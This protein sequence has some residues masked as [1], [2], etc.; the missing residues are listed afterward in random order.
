MD[1]DPVGEGLGTVIRIVQRLADS[2]ILA[3]KFY[4]P[5]DEWVRDQ[6]FMFGHMFSHENIA[7]SIEIVEASPTPCIIMEYFPTDMTRT[8][9]PR[10][11]PT[12]QIDV[13]FKQILTGIAHMHSLGIAHR[14]IKMDNV[15]L[16][17]YGNA[18]IIDFGRAGIG[19]HLVSGET[20]LVYGLW[21]SH[22]YSAPECQDEWKYDPHMADIWS[23]GVLYISM[24]LG[25]LPW[26]SATAD[27]E[28]FAGYFH[29]NNSGKAELMTLIQPDSRPLIDVMLNIDPFK[30]PNMV[31]VFADP[32]IQK[33]QL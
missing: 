10:R 15:V 30:R 20:E 26:E 18:K 17:E 6:E 16:D 2:K 33:I 11:L 1:E 32:W 5:L 3:A 27:D 9:V 8:L 19:R 28:A 24:I 31:E 12:S 23:L 7:H 13:M 21:G 22:P 4:D 25:D 14:D 29:P